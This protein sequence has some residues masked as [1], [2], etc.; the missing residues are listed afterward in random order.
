MDIFY[1]RMRDIRKDN[2]KS[3]KQIAEILKITQQQYQ[4]Y[5]SGKRYI[6]I[7][8]LIEFCNYF[9]VSSDYI[10]GLEQGLSW[11]RETRKGGKAERATDPTKSIFC[12]VSEHP[13]RCAPRMFFIVTDLSTGGYRKS[14]QRQDSIP[15][16]EAPGKSFG[17]DT[18]N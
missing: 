15:G 9:E 12:L 16:A 2:D 3:Q 4:L 6:P 7:D 14:L 11:P 5:E 13:G 10:L 17:S 18:V 8:L 1:N